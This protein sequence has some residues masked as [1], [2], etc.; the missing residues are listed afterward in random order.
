MKSG[1]AF[2]LSIL[3]TMMFVS[4]VSAQTNKMIPVRE[5]LERNGFVTEWDAETKTAVFRNDDRT[6]SVT[7]GSEYFEINGRKITFSDALYEKENLVYNAPVIIDGSF[8]LPENE[9]MQAISSDKI[10]ENDTSD[11][12]SDI[13]HRAIPFKFG[14]KDECIEFFKQ[15]DKYY[16]LLN[17][18]DLNWRMRKIGATVEEYK[19]YALGEALDFTDEETL[20]YIE[21]LA[22]VQDKLNALGYDYTLDKQIVFFKTTTQEEMDSGAYTFENCIFLGEWLYDYYKENGEDINNYVEEV[23]AHEIFHV[24]T[25]NDPEF[26]AKMYKAI[27]FEIGEEPDFSSEVKA[28]LVSNPDVEKFD[29]Y[30]Y[31]TLNGE[32]KK[33]TVVSYYSSDYTDGENAF[34]YICPGIVF[35]D[36]PDKIYPAEDIS[37]FYDVLGKN[38]D[39]VIAAEECM[40]DNFSFAVVEGLDGDY[41]E[42]QIIEYIVSELRNQS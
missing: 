33:G 15:N 11:V 14:T 9:L 26:R 13:A 2:S 21:R 6:V 16:N 37:D 17:Q 40:A 24:L 28:R 32:K 41:N 22:G 1:E 35:Y 36:E 4:N 31:F 7:A 39:Y 29:C 10:K 23:F 27:G 19:N 5:T 34:D 20:Y 38:T 25:R 42:P 18:T 12:S 30:S 8:Y 3:C